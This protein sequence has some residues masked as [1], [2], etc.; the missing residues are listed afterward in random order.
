[1]NQI[2]THIRQIEGKSTRKNPFWILKTSI[3]S[4]WYWTIAHLHATPGLDVHARIFFLGLRSIVKSKHMSKKTLRDA[5]SLIFLS[6]DSV[7][8]FEFGFIWKTIKS[9]PIRGRYLDISSPR[10][11]PFLLLSSNPSLNVE[12]VNPDVND[13]NETKKVAKFLNLDS[14]CNYY[15]KLIKDVD[16]HISSFNTITCISVIEHI[17]GYGDLEAIIKI[18]SLL[19]SGGTFL[20][21]VPCARQAFEEYMDFNEYGLLETGEDNFTFGQRFYDEQLL[22]ERIFN[23]TGH[24]L[25]FKIYGER[26]EGSFLSN[27]DSRLSNPNYPFWRE[28]YMMGVDYC[29]FNSISEMPGWGV[30]AM[31]FRKP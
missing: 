25:A 11:V 24:P 14:R 2:Y 17:P 29:F 18:W 23:V 9:N 6:I 19:E 15:N 26:M 27:R 12:M 1:M 20:L 22:Q 30:I 13:I 5:F 28:P 21:S 7:R 8:Y 10:L 4:T 31:E 16:F 3:L